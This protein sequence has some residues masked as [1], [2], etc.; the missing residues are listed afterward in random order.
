[1]PLAFQRSMIGTGGGIASAAASVATGGIPNVAFASGSDAKFGSFAVSPLMPVINHPSGS[2]TQIANSNG[3]FTVNPTDPNFYLNGQHAW[4]IE[5]WLANRGQAA[6]S[7]STPSGIFRLE[8]DITQGSG[9]LTGGG[10]RIIQYSDGQSRFRVYG[11]SY[12]GDF[13]YTSTRQY[14]H[15]ALTSNGSNQLRWWVDGSNVQTFNYSNSTQRRTFHM[16]Q[17][18]D[19]GGNSD[20]TVLFD[21]LRISNVDRYAS[22]YYAQTTAFTTDENT[23]ALFHLDGNFTDSSQG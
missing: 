7:S 9:N 22:G 1:M 14:L 19:F 23:L 17:K 5:F 11:E 18:I 20:M 16:G 21:E 13:Y 3:S 10:P 15:Y 6:P 2:A 12:A 4:T 8:G